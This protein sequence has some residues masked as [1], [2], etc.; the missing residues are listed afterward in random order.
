M[1]D[2]DFV[3]ASMRKTGDCISELESALGQRKETAHIAQMPARHSTTKRQRL[4]HRW[5]R[6]SWLFTDTEFNERRFSSQQVIGRLREKEAFL[7][8]VTK[9]LRDL[10]LSVDE[11]TREA[12]KHAGI[13]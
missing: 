13:R 6:L 10:E 4:R 1:N 5:R 9:Q 8:E 12:H 11:L 7:S 3:L 2:I